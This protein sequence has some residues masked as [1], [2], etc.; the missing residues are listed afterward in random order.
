MAEDLGADV[1]TALVRGYHPATSPGV[2]FVPMPGNTVVRWS[3][4]GLGTDLADPKTSHPTPWDYHQRVPIVLYGPGFINEG[5]RAG[6]SV[7]LTYVAPSFA[8]LMPV[9]SGDAGD[10]LPFDFGP[11]GARDLREAAPTEGGV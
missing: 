8:S 10:G 3:G 4:E 2:A 6:R 9:P 1:V 5:K 11:L 7:D